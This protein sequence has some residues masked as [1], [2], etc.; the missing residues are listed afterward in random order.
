MKV[1]AENPTPHHEPPL[2]WKSVRLIPFD[3]MPGWVGMSRPGN[4]SIQA[5]VA[6]AYSL[7]ATSI[8]VYGH[9]M[10]GTI[11]AAGYDG[12]YRT[13]ER[14]GRERLDW[15]ASREWAENHGLTIN[16]IKDS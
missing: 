10:T 2:E 15:A 5:A 4:W 9:D 12:D 1:V 13:G 11:D 16:E 7:G 14:W 3:A 6:G 8:D